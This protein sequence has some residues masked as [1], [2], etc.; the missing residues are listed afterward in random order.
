MIYPASILIVDDTPTNLK[1]LVEA[2]D[3]TG[4]E[5][6]VAKTG[7]SALKKARQSLPN[8]ILLDICMKG[9]DGF[10]TCQALKAD[11]LTCS[12]PIIFMTALNDDAVKLKGFKAGAV[13]Y[14][15]KPV[16]LE[17]AIARISVHLQ[18]RHSH[19]QLLNEI[20][21][22]QETEQQLQHTLRS[23]QETQVQLIQA[24]KLAGLGQMMAGI[25]HEINN[26]INFIHGNLEH[27]RLYT[28]NLLRLVDCYTQYYSNPPDEIQQL[29]AS[30]DLSFIQEDLP[31]LVTSIELGTVRTQE[32]IRSL[33][34]FSRSGEEGAKRV[35][36]HEGIDSTLL[37]LGH[38]LSASSSRSKI[39]LIKKMDLISQV[40]CFPGFLNQVF[41]NLFANAIDAIDEKA[42]ISNAFCDEPPAIT[43]SMY[44]VNESVH[45]EV[46]D[47]GIGVPDAIKEKLFDPFFTTKPVGHGTGLGLSICHEIIANRHQGTI[48][49]ASLATGGSV[50]TIIIPSTQKQPQECSQV[51]SNYSVPAVP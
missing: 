3:K 4:F 13:D 34:I 22:R 29:I 11:P 10:E 25:A 24:E 42:L 7:E 43:I 35:N 8:L 49:C 38:R 17:E 37:L 30:I 40:E 18:L 48:Q 6:F 33:Q 1:V 27:L 15:T 16:Q 31:D 28:S 12:I 2:F 5:S 36:I 9:M 44:Q 41:M 47:N 14:I 23:L 20:A 39:E 46:R 26:P 32:I 19:Q 45:L 51:K 21:T 50:F